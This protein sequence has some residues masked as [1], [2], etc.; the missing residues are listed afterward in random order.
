[1]DDIHVFTQCESS[2][3]KVNEINNNRYSVDAR[4]Y[5]N[6]FIYTRNIHDKYL[7]S[8]TAKS[9]SY[10]Y[11]VFEGDDIN[12]KL[13]SWLVICDNTPN[14]IYLYNVYNIE[15]EPGTPLR[16][17]YSVDEHNIGDKNF[18]YD[19]KELEK[20]TEDFSKKLNSTA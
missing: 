19:Q 15:T 14:N 12:D 10:K 13:C 9:E 7:I 11:I 1:M 18:I 6:V 17:T 20:I 2:K 8:G 4:G 5:E 16:E 3:L